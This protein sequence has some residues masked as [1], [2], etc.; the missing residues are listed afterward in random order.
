M[1]KKYDVVISGDIF[2]DLIFT[3][4]PRMP[5]PGEELFATDFDMTAGA[6]FI[7]ATTLLAAR[8]ERRPLLPPG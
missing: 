5:L 1:P 2:C 8:H 4:L 6:V 3:G 7:T